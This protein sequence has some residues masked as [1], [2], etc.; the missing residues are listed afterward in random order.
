MACL[1]QWFIG[2]NVTRVCDVVHFN[3][4]WLLFPK[5]NRYRDWLQ[6]IETGTHRF[7]PLSPSFHVLDT[8]YQLFWTIMQ[9]MVAFYRKWTGKKPSESSTKLTNMFVVIL[10]LVKFENSWKEKLVEW[11]NS[12]IPWQNHWYMRT[13]CSSLVCLA[14]LESD[15]YYIQSI[16]KWCGLCWSLCFGKP[17]AVSRHG[18]LQALHFCSRGRR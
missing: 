13:L 11:W 16:I 8:N 6:L 18:R 3:G 7:L 12:K 14:L 15:D 4:N 5:R 10:P 1:S 9:W 17:Q 2:R